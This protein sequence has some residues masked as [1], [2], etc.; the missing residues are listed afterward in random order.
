MLF[1]LVPSIDLTGG[2]FYTDMKFDVQLVEALKDSCH[3]L[4]LNATFPERGI[5]DKIRIIQDDNY[6]C[7]TDVH[8]AINKSKLCTAELEKTDIERLLNVLVIEEKIIPYE[9]KLNIK[10]EREW[11]YKAV[12]PD[13]L[14]VEIPLSSIPCGNCPVIC[15]L[16]S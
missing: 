12:R 9:R 16:I 6:M 2:V 15:F 5:Y 4:I 10:N 14:P 13:I 1:D 11:C 8:E 3:K 7:L